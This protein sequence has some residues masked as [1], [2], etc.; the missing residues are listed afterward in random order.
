MKTYQGTIT[1]YRFKKADN[2][3]LKAK[4]KSSKDAREYLKEIFEE[5][6]MEVY[7]SFYALFLNRANITCG[8]VKISQGGITGTVVDERLIFKAALDC[9]ATSMILS[10]NHPSGNIAPSEADKLLTK[11]I[12]QAGI[13]LDIQVRDHV[14][15]TQ[16]SYY[17][18]AD[19]GIL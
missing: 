10:H 3:I 13:I 19:E 17:S 12:K 16:D 8:F 15:L 4:I 7:E 5:D 2:S 18:F 9:Y 11:K 1:E 14:I 6:T